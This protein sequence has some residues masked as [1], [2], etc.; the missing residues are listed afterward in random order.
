[1]KGFFT[2]TEAGSVGT[3]AVLLL[4]LIKKGP[5]LEGV[6]E[7]RRGIAADRL[8]G[9]DAHRRLHDPGPFSGGDQNSHDRA[10]WII[11]LGLN[12]DLTMI[13]IALIYL[14]GRVLYR[15]PGLYD[16]GDSD[17]LPRDH[18]TGL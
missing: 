6:S 3:F 8:H 12:R 1:M 17:L 10:D 2:P 7:I 11:Q 5:D 18:Q 13:L 9:P 4:A 15:R 16:P 14:I